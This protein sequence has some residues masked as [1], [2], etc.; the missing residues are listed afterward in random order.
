MDPTL[1]AI[2]MYLFAPITGLIW[3]NDSNDFV[4]F[5]AKQSL[6][7]GLANV[8]IWVLLTLL[9][10]VLVGACLMPVWGLV[11]FGVTIYMIIEMNKGNKTKLPVI[12]DMAEK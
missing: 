10:A 11:Y 4:K 5:H 2:L 7:L 12:G 8:V 9:S 3:M 6:Y 1:Q